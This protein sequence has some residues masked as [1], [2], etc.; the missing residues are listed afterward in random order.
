M[1]EARQASC[2]REAFV[3]FQVLSCSGVRCDAPTK[4]R[5]SPHWHRRQRMPHTPCRQSH[6]LGSH[7]PPHLLR[8][9]E[10]M[11][12][13]LCNQTEHIRTSNCP[14]WVGVAVDCECELIVVTCK[15][16]TRDGALTCGSKGICKGKYVCMHIWP[17]VAHHMRRTSSRVR[18]CGLRQIYT[19]PAFRVQGGR[20]EPA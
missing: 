14:V 17:M 12:D 10:S 20:G 1:R 5:Y 15:A 6:L 7:I 8:C 2:A 16:E 19:Q 18:H 11:H 3:A 9:S 13:T 4:T